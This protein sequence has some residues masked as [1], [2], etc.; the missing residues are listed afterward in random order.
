VTRS[1]NIWIFKQ[2]TNFHPSG[3]FTRAQAI[4]IT[5]RVIEGNQPEPYPDYRTNYMNDAITLGLIQSMNPTS[6]IT[7]W[8]VANLLHDASA[9][10]P[11]SQIDY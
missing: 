10:A 8:E 6:T 5:M 1:C 4:T 9:Y 7:R 2:Q 11:A 3:T